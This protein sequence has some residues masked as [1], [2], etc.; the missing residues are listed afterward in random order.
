[1][2][3]VAVIGG[4]PGGL[5][6]ARLLEQK[7]PRECRIT[8]F[9]AS[10][11]LGGKLQT[12]RFDSA[13]V[14]Y[15]AGVAECY[16][17]EAFGPDPLKDLVRALGLVPLP[18]GGTAVILGGRILRDDR[19][20]ERQL[21]HRTLEAIKGFRQ[22]AVL[23]VSPA[24]WYR[25]FGPAD[26]RDPWATRTGRDLLDEVPDPL[27]RRYL[28]VVM[29]SDLATEPH[30]VNGLVGL[31]NALKSVEG[32]GAQYTVAGGIEA[33]GRSL[34]AS[35]AATSVY[36]G[37]P[38]RAVS[39][40]RGGGYLV[41][42]QR[43]G[44]RE[45]LPFDAVIAALPYYLLPRIAWSG[46]RLARAMDAHVARYDNPGHYL[47]IA[48]LFERPFWR[49]HVHGSWMMLDAFGGCCGYDESPP[50]GG[51]GVLNLLLAGADALTLCNADDEVLVRE[52][53]DALP[54]I[55][56]AE[57]RRQLL[58][59][60]VHRWAGAL[61]GSPGGSPMVEPGLAH[62]PEPVFHPRLA[63]VGDYLFDSTLNGV[64]RSAEIATS[65]VLER[66]LAHGPFLP[67]RQATR[68]VAV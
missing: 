3:S 2:R 65:L 19:D 40:A 29:H 20:V 4:G 41:T 30:Q 38:V 23:R 67:F 12:R 10:G 33:F 27:A 8:L 36:T 59:G 21:G 61:S 44:R 37:T 55:L 50:N 16:D 22:R 54:P 31:R 57:G 48:L 46:D 11:R 58:E 5:M 45:S 6:A 7:A 42:V 39:D 24:R 32:Y 47:R 43:E 15:E 52:A 35:L 34:A 56:R 66:P 68:P 63:V 53:V 51:R 9:E 14:T 26:R 17:Y 64:L 18:T 60:R 1:M 25:G 28:H 62:C 13:D 49:T